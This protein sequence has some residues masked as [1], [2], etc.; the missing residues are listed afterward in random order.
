[1]I[2]DKK[3]KYFLLILI[4]S[5]LFIFSVGNLYAQESKIGLPG[6]EH[7]KTIQKEIK[8]VSSSL[9][10]RIRDAISEINQ[11]VPFFKNSSEKIGSWWYLETKPWIE[12]QWKNFNNYMEKEI[13]LE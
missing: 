5:M 8:E 6:P 10:Q 11:F 4:F 7:V 9:F 1:M 2:G 12:L 13:R 3:L